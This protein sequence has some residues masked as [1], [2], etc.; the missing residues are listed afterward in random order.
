MKPIIFVRT[1]MSNIYVFP[2]KIVRKVGFFQCGASN[3]PGETTIPIDSIINVSLTDNGTHKALIF[4]MSTNSANLEK[5][6]IKYS[7]GFARKHFAAAE[8]IQSY[9]EQSIYLRTHQNQE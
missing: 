8:K 7:L 5:Q 1:K 9:V 4:E 3:P 2:D 6:P